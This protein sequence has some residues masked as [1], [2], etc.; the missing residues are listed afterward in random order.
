MDEER[1]VG[2]YWQRDQE[3]IRQTRTS[4][5][6]YVRTI[7]Y[8]ILQDLEDTEECENDV[9]LKIWNSIPEDRPRIFSAYIGRICRND[10]INK[11]HSKR[12]KKRGSGQVEEIYEELEGLVS[13]GFSVENE[14]KTKEF[15][16]V[17]NKFLDSLS[18]EKRLVFMRRYWYGDSYGDLARETGFSIGKLKT[19]TFRIRNELRDLLKKEG[20]WDEW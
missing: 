4:Y 7:A 15:Y 10:A 16:R 13:E 12:A 19:M 2:L 3:A 1:L 20:I 6:A 9:Y 8:N 5:G 17:L 18:K 11:Y 14:I